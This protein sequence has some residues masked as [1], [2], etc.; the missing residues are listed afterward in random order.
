MSLKAQTLGGIGL[1]SL[2]PSLGFLESPYHSKPRKV[3][4]WRS[5]R[6]AAS[7]PLGTRM[8]LT[9]QK[10][11]LGSSKQGTWFVFIPTKRPFQ[12]WGSFRNRA[13]RFQT[14]FVIRL[15]WMALFLN[16]SKMLNLIIYTESV[17]VVSDS[18][19]MWHFIPGGSS[20]VVKFL[21]IW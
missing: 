11:W 6:T 20:Q 10:L 15:I 4:S 9:P 12:S 16:F 17:S 7:V 14:E 21:R 2:K 5:V 18:L 13:W 3:A 1:A 19:C 8:S